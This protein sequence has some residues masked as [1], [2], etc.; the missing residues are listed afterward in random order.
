[1]KDQGD[2]GEFDARNLP[3]VGRKELR[4]QLL[5]LLVEARDGAGTT[6]LLAGELG[7]GKTRLTHSLEEEARQRGF[8][9]AAGRAYQAEASVPYALLSD[10]FLPFLQGV[11]LE[12]LNVLSRGNTQELRHF[13]PTLDLGEVELHE[14]SE[15]PAELRTRV[16]WSF[17][18]LLRGLSRRDPLL[19]VLE[20]L[21]WADSSSLEVLHFLARQLHDQPVLIVVTCDAR[22]LER[23]QELARLGHSLTT[24]GVAVR[25]DLPPLTRGETGEMLKEAFGAGDEV[26]GSFIDLLYEW[27]RG[28]PFFIQEVLLALVE[29]GHLHRKG[30]TWLGWEMEEMAL[31]ASVRQAALGRLDPLPPEARD[32]AEYAAILGSPF[33]FR[34]LRAVS[35]LPEPQL[36]EVLDLLLD[37]GIL[38]ESEKEGRVVYDFSQRLLR[39][40][41]VS[42]L[43]LARTRLLHGEVARTLRDHSVGA[44]PEG[45]GTLAYHFLRSG[46][47]GGGPD[48]LPHLIVAGRE[49]LDR[50][51]NQEAAHY[52]R[53]ALRYIEARARGSET[54]S[55]AREPGEVETDGGRMGVVRDLARALSRLG[56]YTDALP[57]WQEAIREAEEAGD[58]RSACDFRRRLATL[59]SYRGETAEALEELDL[60]LSR[61]AHHPAPEVE[62]RTRLR[63]GICLEEMGHPAEAK[64]EMEG[65][66]EM[67]GELGDQTLLA[68]AHRALV[69]LHI[70]SGHPSRVRDHARR[71]LE[72]SRTAGAGVV[73]FWTFWGLA[74]QEGLLGDT[75][76][77]GELLEGA[78]EVADA[79]GSPLLSLRSA[80][81]VIEK[82]AAA[83][84]WEMAITRGERAIAL[85]RDLSQRS[86]LVRLLAWTSLVYLGRGEVDLARPLIEEA[87]EI[88]GAEGDSPENIHSLLPALIGRGY[89]ALAEGDY[90][91]AAKWARKGLARADGAGYT[92]WSIH[93]LLPL[94]GEACLWKRDL[95]GARE[96][97]E[98]LRREAEPLDHRLGLAWARA[99]EALVTWLE[100]DPVL[101]AQQ[102]EEAARAL[103][104]IPMIPDAARL[105]RQLAGRLAETGDREGALKELTRVHEIFL[106]MGAGPELEKTRGMFRE[107]DS[108]PPRKTQEGEGELSPR[109]TEIARLVQERKSNKAIARALGISPRTVS[110][111][112]SNIYEKLGIGKRGELADYMRTLGH[113]E[114]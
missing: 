60:V 20:D 75:R 32:I 95:Q 103:E 113:G 16:L 111:H 86:L 85:A 2:S 87:W 108:R 13:F 11:P 29:G 67:A 105:R 109:E 24:H 23:S 91:Q 28:N 107:I 56:Y 39:E 45:A 92:L 6:V 104:E 106:R 25:I 21:Q 110:T 77:M 27:T 93:R 63:R 14:P 114:E 78:E 84:D 15:S 88:S 76:Q 31:P 52:L 35:P 100:G 37:Q 42:E 70:W 72:L 49:A 96:V 65:A 50:M 59:R 7:S 102:M 82:A 89:L 90:D 69:L 4:Q 30:D 57:L 53:A 47:E 99:C 3:L 46:P 73:E 17:A 18:E 40:A 38:R 19:M 44:E 5:D 94:L 64:K 48:A 54:E 101:G 26:A 9:V 112:L 22:E 41:I 34:R 98:R 33:P 80:E 66:L 58:E 81:L 8:Q 68:A 61:L 12:T 1:M 62:A 10:A 51:A 43:G 83:G 97:G 79:L 55:E 36:L 71:A 74:V